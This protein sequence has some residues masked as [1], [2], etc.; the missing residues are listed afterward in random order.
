LE[1]FEHGLK[2]AGSLFGRLGPM[3]PPDTAR[4]QHLFPLGVGAELFQPVM[5]SGV[6]PITD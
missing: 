6:G 3:A 1:L 5:A 2:P 4:H